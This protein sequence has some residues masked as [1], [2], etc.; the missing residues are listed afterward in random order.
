MKFNHLNVPGHWRH[1]W[2]R[3]PEGYTI[4][5][6]LVS[7]VSQVDLMVD[8]QN[9]LND[10]VTDFGLRLDDFIEQF[11]ENLREQTTI[12]LKDWQRTGFLGEIITEALTWELDTYIDLNEDDKQSIIDTIVNNNL[13]TN[14]RIDLLVG[15]ENGSTTG[16]AELTDVR[17]G[18]DGTTYDTAGTAVRAVSTGQNVDK[19]IVGN[20]YRKADHYISGF[21][22][23]T[24]GDIQPVADFGY[25]KIPVT[26][27]LSYVLRTNNGDYT[28]AIGSLIFLNENDE[29]IDFIYPLSQKKFERYNNQDYVR[30][31]TPAN[32]RYIA[33]TVKT[34]T[35]D[36]STNLTVIQATELNEKTDRP[37]EIGRLYTLPI[38]DRHARLM[39]DNAIVLTGGNLYDKSKHYVP[40]YYVNIDGE[41]LYQYNWGA[42]RFP[43]QGG[44]VYSLLLQSGDYT[45]NIGSLAFQDANGITLEYYYP[46]RDAING[47]YNGTQYVTLTA[48]RNAKYLLGSLNTTHGDNSEGVII[49]Q[50]DVINDNTLNSTITSIQG[51][52]IANVNGLTPS[53]QMTG[54]KW[55][56]FGDS[57]TEA[58]PRTTKNY[59]GY[60][61]EDLGWSVTNMGVSGTGYKRTSENNTAFYQR[62]SS[63]PLDTDVITIFGSLNDLGAGVPLGTP[64][65]TGTDTLAGAI[66]TTLDNLN[67]RLPVVPVG[68]IS[69]TPWQSSKPWDDTSTATQ[70]AKLLKDIC[71]DRGLPF[72]D[73]YHTS[74]LRPWEAEYRTLMYSRDGGSGVHP[75]ENGHK[76]I[77]SKFR[78][79]VK[80]LI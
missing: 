36:M 57:L 32:T 63:V 4:L 37:S 54:K 69:P 50:S 75:D 2:T 45:G 60:V 9:K 43:V 41:Y 34:P 6:A 74:G 51:V 11:D 3:Y 13:A 62:I 28:G 27:N 44:E 53:L 80:T 55:V 61:A 67:T 78:E 52:P 48:P 49:V 72:L 14:A 79:F 19:T 64:S 59:H 29:R 42:L 35:F 40:D 31:T 18:Y 22:A 16:D 73:L 30:F 17:V 8:N 33:V 71:A 26:E 10:T 76:F 46:A 5:E 77:A 20:V 1:Y 23:N 47:E 15:L 66:N 25:A 58:N 56:A 38:A 12:I 70:Y 24:T 68:I 21:L 65:D 39:A 7:W